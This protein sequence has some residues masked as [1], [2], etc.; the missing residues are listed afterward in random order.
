MASRKHIP[1]QTLIDFALGN[2][3]EAE[4]ENVISH[5]HQCPKCESILEG[6]E[7]MLPAV[8]EEKEAPSSTLKDRLDQRID[9]ENKP[10][11]RK[12]RPKTV[13]WLGGVAAALLLAFGLTTFNSGSNTA[14]NED[15]IYN[16]EINE[17]QVQSRPDTK[18][19]EIIPVSRF[20]HVSGNVWINNSTRE[21]LVEI[22][23]LADLSGKNY[24]IWMIDTDDNV[25]GELL[26]IQNGSVRI[27]YQGEGVDQ[28]KL[29]KTSVEPAGGSEQP[30]GPEP[31]S[32]DLPR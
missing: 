6:W 30:T 11:K 15:V 23:G 31:F 19:L 27:L 32:V 2:L 22:D 26:P 17:A 3:D 21:I 5:I 8:N 28:F 25:Y 10:A 12:R 7:R 24:Q 29:I 18:R 13:Y 9:E 1:E 4:C 14:L 16:D 20:D